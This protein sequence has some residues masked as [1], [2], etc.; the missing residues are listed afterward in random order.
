ME[1]LLEYCKN[2]IIDHID[3]YEGTMHYACDFPMTI[4]EGP[5]CD[6]SLTYSTDNAIEFLREWWWDCGEYWKYE[7]FNFGEN[8]HNPFENPEAYM[9]CMVIEGCNSILSRCPVIEEN[10]ND[11]IEITEEVIKQIKEYV[12]DYDNEELF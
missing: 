8:Y 10:W 6:G 7:K 1:T 9:V 2:Y 11:K 4:T 5:N 3:N 12:E